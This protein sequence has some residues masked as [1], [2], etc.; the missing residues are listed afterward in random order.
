MQTHANIQAPL[1]SYGYWLDC[2]GVFEELNIVWVILSMIPAS[3]DSKTEKASQ[4]T[5]IT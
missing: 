1:Q 2:V 5:R 3:W 4:N